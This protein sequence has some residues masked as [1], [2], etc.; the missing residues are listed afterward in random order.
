MQGS[1]ELAAQRPQPT[2]ATADKFQGGNGFEINPESKLRI[3]IADGTVEFHGP[4]VE[5]PL[6]TENLTDG[7]RGDQIEGSLVPKLPASGQ[8]S[9]DREISAGCLALPSV[10]VTV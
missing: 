10:A 9:A 5:V 8:V 2:L 6:Q 7:R 1:E 4:A 3:D